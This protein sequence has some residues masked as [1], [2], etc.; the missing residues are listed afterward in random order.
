MLLIQKRI[1]EPRA[2]VEL[3]TCRLR[4]GCSTT[5]LPR[6][7]V[8]TIAFAE[9]ECQFAGDFLVRNV[10]GRRAKADLCFRAARTGRDWFELADRLSALHKKEKSPTLR[11]Q[12]CDDL[13]VAHPAPYLNL[14]ARD[15]VSRADPTVLKL[16]AYS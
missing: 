15:H 2:R 5:E 14:I 9:K 8:I 1:L 10:L 16:A 4:I 7:G 3:A 13:R 6:L 11:S 12:D